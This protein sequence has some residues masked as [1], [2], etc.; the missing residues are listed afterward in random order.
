MPDVPMNLI[1]GYGGPSV[2]FSLRKVCNNLRDYIDRTMPELHL[3]AI[4]IC[5]GYKRIT[6]TWSHYLENVEISYMLHGNGYKT[7]VGENEKF[8]ENVDYMEGF[9]NDYN[10]LMKFQNHS[11]Q[12]FEL[13]MN[14]SMDVDDVSKFLKQY[15]NS[16]L[17]KTQYLS[18]GI[19]QGDKFPMI[20]Q[21]LDANCLNSIRFFRRRKYDKN[22]D[23]TEIVKL[24]QWK[25]AK[26]FRSDNLEISA[27]MKHFT[28]FSKINTEFEYIL[29]EPESLNVL[30]EAAI[31][32]P[33]F[34]KFIIE[35]HTFIESRQRL[36]EVFGKPFFHDDRQNKWLWFFNTC[37][38]EKILKIDNTEMSDRIYFSL[39]DSSMVP[40]GA[41]VKNL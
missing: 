35:Y 7:I 41:E 37:R 38:E 20:L 8:V 40:N 30:K 12:S 29:T 33:K 10:L 17:I 13:E 26:E 11:L 32:S 28:H 21:H 3:K 19:F 1:L 14:N 9:W 36:S 22:I 15:Q 2:I 6:I 39:I 23:F 4:D 31:R 34:E 27:P 16:W 24:D 18:L 25:N 5:L